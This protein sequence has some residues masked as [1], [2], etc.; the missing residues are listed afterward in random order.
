MVIPGYRPVDLPPPERPF[1]TVRGC[2]YLFVPSRR[3][4]AWLAGLQA[5]S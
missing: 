3:A 1:V 5:T 4:S 2:E